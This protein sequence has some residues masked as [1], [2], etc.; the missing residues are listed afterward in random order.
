MLL[1]LQRKCKIQL[2]T[3]AES[4]LL[5]FLRHRLVT[6]EA[7]SRLNDPQRSVVCAIPQRLRGQVIEELATSF[8]TNLKLFA[9]EERASFTIHSEHSNR[10][11]TIAAEHWAPIDFRRSSS[12]SVGS[13]GVRLKLPRPRSFRGRGVWPFAALANAEF[14][15]SEPVWQGVPVAPGARQVP[16]PR[17]GCRRRTSMAC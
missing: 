12:K 10:S 17:V 15:C 16:P 9:K 2:A 1:R 7:V 14:R 5:R 3:K 13:F 11:I 8:G 4:H 6:T